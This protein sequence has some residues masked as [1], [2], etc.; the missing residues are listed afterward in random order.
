MEHPLRVLFVCMGNICRS[1]T[2]EA[3]FRAKAREAGLESKIACDS[4]GTIQFHIGDPPDSRMRRAAEQR[5]YSLEGKSRQMTVND[6]MEFDFIVAMDRA[7]LRD[8][9]A[10]DPDETYHAKIRLLTEFCRH[11]KDQDVPDPY[12]SGKH[13]FE[14]V[15]D[16]VED[17]CEGLL[18]TIRQKHL[19]HA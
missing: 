14:K 17:G 4:V 13:G 11:H 10:L 2:A 9:R 1:P 12:Y 19:N 8:I 6:I 3:V 7:N 5:G 15:L 18:E 16:L